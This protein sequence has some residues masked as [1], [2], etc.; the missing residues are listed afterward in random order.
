MKK[1][2]LI[3]KGFAYTSRYSWDKT[4]A[5]ERAK[6]ARKAGYTVKVIK[7]KTKKSGRTGYALVAKLNKTGGWLQRR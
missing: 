5:E 3:P 2:P 6:K 1:K 4:K 7:A